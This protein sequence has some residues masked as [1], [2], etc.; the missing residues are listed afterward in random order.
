MCQMRIEEGLKLEPDRDGKVEI[1]DVGRD[2]IPAFLARNGH[3]V[4]AE[5]GVYKGD[6]AIKFLEAG[7]T[8]YGVDSWKAFRDYDMPNRDFQARQDE[9][10]QG[11]LKRLIPK[12]PD[13]FIPVRKFS[14]DAVLD[15]KENSLDFVYIDGHH[16]FKYVVEDLWEWTRIVK[17]GGI[18]CGHDY[19]LTKKSARDP[20]VLHVKYALHGFVAAFKISPYY[21]LGRHKAPEG[22]IR[23]K[24]RSWMF[25][26]PA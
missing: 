4:G 9:L 11:V 14:M 7:L 26:N 25:V 3:M 13:T 18:I 19:A 22:E 2:D 17:P 20:M 16:G 24:W 23:D 15:F 6:F 1:P 5:I 10:Y 12:Y 8:L 21:I